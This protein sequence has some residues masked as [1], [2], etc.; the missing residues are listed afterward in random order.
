MTW[1]DGRTYV[2]PVSLPSLKSSAL[3]A[4][5]AFPSTGFSSIFRERKL[6]GIVVP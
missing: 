5:S 3:E 4:E 6:S 1:S 2:I